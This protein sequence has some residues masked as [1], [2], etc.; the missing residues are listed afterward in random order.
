MVL[1]R[2]GQRLQPIPLDKV[3]V[4]NPEWVARVPAVGI[5]R[6][7]NAVLRAVDLALVP[8]AGTLGLAEGLTVYP[9][10][11]ATERVR[12]IWREAE[13]TSPIFDNFDRIGVA[14][15][16]LSIR[17]VRRQNP[18]PTA[19]IPAVVGS[20]IQNVFLRIA[21]LGIAVP[22]AISGFLEG[23]IFYPVKRIIHRIKQVWKKEPIVWKDALIDRDT[24]NQ[25]ETTAEQGVDPSLKNVRN[26]EQ[27]IQEV[28]PE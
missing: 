1:D 28:D 18:E 21:A 16:P 14:I 11:R 8:L 6:I 20:F 7:R 3:R 10:I 19:R 24:A 17:K 9:A 4:Q 25:P 15:Q 23:L 26:T 2:I 12:Q 27:G 13:E 22:A 5:T